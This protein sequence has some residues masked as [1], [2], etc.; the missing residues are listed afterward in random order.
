VEKELECDDC[1]TTEDVE[2]TS[3]PYQSDVNNKIVPANL[4][5]KC[6]QQRCEDI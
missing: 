4:C 6:N 1:G 2:E 5:P 3:C